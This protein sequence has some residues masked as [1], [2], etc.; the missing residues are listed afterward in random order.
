MLKIG[1]FSRLGKVPVKTL[2]FYDEV[3]LLSPIHVDGGTGY[4][5]YTLHQ[6]PRLNR[7]LVFKDLGFSL[8][9]IVDLLERDV[10]VDRIRDLL[11]VKQSELERRVA[12][13]RARLARLEARIAQIDSDGMVPAYDV[14]LREVGP[15]LVA[16]RRDTLRSY[17]AAADLLD[18][19]DRYVRRNGATGDRGALWHACARSGRAI[20]CEALV[21]LR[22]PVPT[23]DRVA[24]YELP[25]QTMA[26]VVHSGSD[27]DTERA[28]EAAKCW[29]HASAYRVVG[30]NRE[31]Y[32]HEDPRRGTSI[33]EIQI[34]VEKVARV[35]DA[36]E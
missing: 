14:V 2:R 9:E 27:E 25:R 17:C 11:R 13:E 22:D 36:S 24:V 32:F 19:I 3:G 35:E 30:P 28:Y 10:P 29:I 21:F 5:Y 26:C 33:L 31:L 23:S 1:D 34:P 20:D 6:L 4:R 12:A 7:I 16:S 15:K 8:G 18:E